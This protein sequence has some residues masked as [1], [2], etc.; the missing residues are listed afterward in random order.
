MNQFQFLNCAPEIGKYN[1]RPTFQGIE[2]KTKN[3]SHFK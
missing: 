2:K 3:E 1:K